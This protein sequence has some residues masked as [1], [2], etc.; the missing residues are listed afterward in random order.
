[1]FGFEE[2]ELE[3]SEI[4]MTFDSGKERSAR[5]ESN[6]GMVALQATALPLGYGRVSGQGSSDV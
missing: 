3:E 6:R 2:A 4:P 5:P 1:M